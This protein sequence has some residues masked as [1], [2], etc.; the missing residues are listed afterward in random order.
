VD[1]DDEDEAVGPM[2]S[3][4][5]ALAESQLLGLLGL[6]EH[7]IGREGGDCACD[8]SPPQ[9]VVHATASF[10][11][12]AIA[13]GAGAVEAEEDER[14]GPTSAGHQSLDGVPRAK[15]QPAPPQGLSED[16]IGGL[17]GGGDCAS[18][19]SPQAAHMET[20]VHWGSIVCLF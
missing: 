1:A 4:R 19:S 2:S 18:A 14:G 12:A 10:C 8:L 7:V 6:S 16:V 11:V 15:S 3:G 13:A 17:T 9:G 20:R 5:Q